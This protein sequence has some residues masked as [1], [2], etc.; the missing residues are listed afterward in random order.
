MS[1]RLYLEDVK[2][3]QR[4]DLFACNEFWIGEEIW[5]SEELIDLGQWKS[6][7]EVVEH[8]YNNLGKYYFEQR[9]D[10]ANLRDSEAALNVFANLFSGGFN[11]GVFKID[12]GFQLPESHEINCESYLQH[13]NVEFFEAF[14]AKW[15]AYLDQNPSADFHSFI[16]EL[17]EF[18]FQ[19]HMK[20]AKKFVLDNL[21]RLNDLVKSLSE[22]RSEG[23]WE[24]FALTNPAQARAVLVAE[25]EQEELGITIAQT[26]NASGLKIRL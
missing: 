7:R 20:P 15:K 17:S 19:T 24:E 23:S 4:A 6:D 14:F 12:H 25:I 22:L 18:G 2:N 13:D 5:K 8:V 1:K 9:L 10:A 3:T 26:A 16:S 21:D 11:S